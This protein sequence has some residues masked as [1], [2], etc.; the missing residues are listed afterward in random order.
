MRHFVSRPL[1]A[2]LLFFVF[3]LPIAIFGQ[4][5]NTTKPTPSSGKRAAKEA[6]F[7]ADQGPAIKVEK[8]IRKERRT[9]GHK[10]DSEDGDAKPVEMPSFRVMSR[11]RE[12]RLMRGHVFHGDLRAL[13]QIPPIKFERP[14]FEEPQVMPVP[15]LAAPASSS[16]SAPATGTN[17][18]SPSVPAP[19]P[20][21]SFEGLDFATWGAGH[22]PDTNGD[23][24]PTYYIQ[25]INTSI[26][27]FRKSDGVRVAAFTFNSFFNGHFGNLCDTNNFGDPI[28]LY[29]TF[30]DRWIITDFAFTLSGGNPAAP[31]FQCFAVSQS[32]DPVVGGWNFYSLKTAATAADAFNDYPKLGI[33]PDGLYMSS[34]MFAITGGTFQNARVWAFNKA[35]M[36]AGSPTIQI[37]SFD[38]P[39]GEFTLLPS[40]ARLQAGTPPAGT[41]N[42]FTTVFN[43]TNAVSTYK[44]HTDWN[45]AFN[46]TFSG[47]FITI[48]PASWA[49]APG[50]VF[51]PAPGTKI[52]TLAPRLMV[53][54]QYTNIG[55]LESL[56]D[57]HTVLGSAAGTAAPR[58]YQVNVTGGA[59][60]ANT[61]QAAT[62]NPDA[63]AVNRF[64]PS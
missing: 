58:F 29:D 33:W 59:V 4:S 27:I 14:E 25:T 15:Y 23:V 30:E 22:P 50:N 40:N 51:T 54:N 61:T 35:Q 39:A 16:P 18:L 28:V 10:A 1:N 53:Q 57:S 44:F 41:P 46:S 64:M 60:A 24:G 17:A 31:V 38:A 11:P 9:P 2:L 63:S 32:G 55:G 42:Y 56:W 26:G 45:N 8:P 47:P 13:P 19:S 3:L 20:S 62:F 21:S 48:A 7:T 6:T 37:L 36:Y 12:D 49:N 52:D 34:N 43:F 5:Q